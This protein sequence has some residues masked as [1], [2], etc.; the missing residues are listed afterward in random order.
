MIK[1]INTLIKNTIIFLTMKNITVILVKKNDKFLEVRGFIVNE[2]L[3]SFF[4]K[5]NTIKD[6]LFF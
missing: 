4:N 6:I 1:K 2:L 3:D 5:Q